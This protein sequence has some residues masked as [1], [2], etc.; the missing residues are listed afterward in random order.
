MI[1]K[2][3]H[4]PGRRNVLTKRRII[5]SQNNT[6]SAMAAARW[7]SVS[8]NTYKKWA[9]YYNIFNQHKNQSGV[10]IKKGWATYKVPLND[11]LTG[12]RQPP[13][14]YSGKVM[15]KRLVEDG[16]FLDECKNCGYSETNL[17]TDKV[18]LNIDFIDGNR[19]NYK[20]ENL[21]LLCPNCYF[22]F[23]GMFPKSK[24]FCK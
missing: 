15:K 14:R 1:S 12:K 13:Q 6:K 23:N 21:R 17:A 7:L 8:Y 24:M 11:I 3:L 10:G 20:Y 18:C 16:Y 19:Q 22:S 4:I 9:K 2:P 5:E